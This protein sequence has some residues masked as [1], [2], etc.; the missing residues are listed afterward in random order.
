MTAALPNNALQG[1]KL[2]DRGVTTAGRCF[3]DFGQRIEI[4]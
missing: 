3:E 4:S 2:P 1:I